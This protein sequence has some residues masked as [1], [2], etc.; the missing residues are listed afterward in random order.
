MSEEEIAEAIKGLPPE[1]AEIFHAAFKLGAVFGFKFR[2]QN[3]SMLLLTIGLEKNHPTLDPCRPIAK[4][5]AKKQEPQPPKR[6]EG[7]F[8]PGCSRKFHYFVEGRS[9]CLKWGI[10]GELDQDNGN[11][12]AL[13]EDCITCFRGLLKRRAKLGVE[14]IE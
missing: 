13:N 11:K 10:P 2:E 7:W 12:D 8:K 1:I 9:L 3:G 5:D 14:K 4:E 6:E